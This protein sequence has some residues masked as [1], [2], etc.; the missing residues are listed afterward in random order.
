M[1]LIKDVPW[2]ALE[3][4]HTALLAD[5]S[6]PGAPCSEQRTPPYGEVKFVR[7]TEGEW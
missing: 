7:W 2:C 4:G 6:H 1:L 5:H 3:K